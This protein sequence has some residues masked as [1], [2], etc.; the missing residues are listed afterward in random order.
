[1]KLFFIL[2]IFILIPLSI[3][4]MQFFIFVLTHLKDVIYYLFIDIIGYFKYKKYNNFTKFGKITMFVASGTQVFGSGK[5]LSMIKYVLDVYNRYN[6]KLVWS[7]NEQKFVHQKIN[8]ISNVDIK[9]V[10][11]IPFKNVAQFVDIDKYQASDTEIFLFVLDESGAIFNSRE[12]RDNISPEFLNRLLQSR[13]HKVALF[14]TSQ[15][16]NF[17]DKILRQI[18]GVVVECRKSWRFVRNRD[19]N[20]LDLEYALNPSLV[21]PRANSYF[22]ATSKLFDSY[23][24]NQL[25]DLEKHYVPNDFLSTQEILATYGTSD[26]TLENSTHIKKRYKKNQQA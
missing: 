13:K 26:G 14:M 18:C 4:Y 8:I 24:T 16:Y 2:L 22:L 23:N 9:G 7:E 10:N 21:R 6:G 3:S 17:T 5:T 25:A 11:F 19:F 15:R 12:F 20:A 1:M